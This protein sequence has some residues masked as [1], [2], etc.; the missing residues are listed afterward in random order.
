MAGN[1]H[2]KHSQYS[3]SPQ[4]PCRRF[5]TCDRCAARRQARFAD[6]AERIAAAFGP[7]DYAVITPDENTQDA[8]RRAKHAAIRA[9]TTPAAIW[10]VEVGTIAQRLH[11]NLLGPRLDLPAIRNASIHLEQIRTNPR[12]VAAYMTKRKAYPPPDLYEGRAVGTTG[13]VMQYLTQARHLPTVQA[14]ALLQVLDTAHYNR[15]QTGEPAS[16][17]AAAL[18]KLADE[19]TATLDAMERQAFALSTK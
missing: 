11:I 16:H 12:A 8:I 1:E 13:N 15:K 10:S 14:A 9:M 5:I 7:L 17:T 2:A 3:C 4:H 18:R 6:I 19:F